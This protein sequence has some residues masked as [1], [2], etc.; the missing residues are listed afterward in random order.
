M[1]K[2]EIYIAGPVQ[3][4]TDNSLDP[5]RF[6]YGQIEAE[7]KLAE[8]VVHIPYEEKELSSLNASLFAKEIKSRIERV[9][10]M[11]VIV[12][13]QDWN[14]QFLN[15]S[16]ACEAQMGTEANKPV[17]IIADNPDHVPRLLRALSDGPELYSFNT[18]NYQQLFRD[19][20]NPLKHTRN[21]RSSRKL[22]D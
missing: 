10:A 18:V 14:R 16:L 22:I 3:R 8:I 2:V 7:A 15:L 12:I 5:L 19:L 11:V 21:S 9:D 1:E 4:P 20:V 13:R 6:I 17:A